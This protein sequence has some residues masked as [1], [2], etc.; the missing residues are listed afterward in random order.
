MRLFL[1]YPSEVRSQVEEVATR[2]RA[3]GHRVFFAPEDLPSGDSFDDRIRRAIRQ[4]DAFLCFLTPEF[5]A[6]GRYT[7]SELEIARRK[8]PSP[9]GHVLPVRVRELPIEAVPSYLRAV[10]ILEPKGNLAA[11]VIAALAGLKTRHTIKRVTAAFTLLAL[12][13]ALFLWYRQPHLGVTKPDVRLEVPG[14]AGNPDQYT[15]TARSAY[16]GTA[17]DL[18]Q[19]RVEFLDAE[20]GQQSE[21]V[22]DSLPLPMTPGS[23]PDLKF[24]VSLPQ[25]PGKRTQLR[26]CALVQAWSCSAWTSVSQS[27]PEGPIPETILHRITAVTKANDTFFVAMTNPTEV[28]QLGPK[29]EVLRSVHQTGMPTAITIADS[30]VYIATAEPDAVSAFDLLTLE[31]R[32][33]LPITFNMKPGTALHEVPSTEVHSIAANTEGVWINTG[34]G[35]NSVLA[36]ADP[37]NRKWIVPKYQDDIAFDLRDVV[38]AAAGDQIWGA[39]T[40]S[41]PANVYLFYAS[42]YVLLDGHTYDEIGC[43]SGTSTS[44]TREFFLI[45]CDGSIV[46]GDI[47]GGAFKVVKRGAVLPNW[48]T[49]NRGTW[50][51]YVAVVGPKIAVAVNVEHPNLPTPEAGWSSQIYAGESTELAP[52]LIATIPGVHVN[53]LAVTSTTVLAAL[54]H[55]DRSR[56]GIAIPVKR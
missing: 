21:W 1:S 6:L 13:L 43:A 54:I 53:S 56:Q 36:H 9:T 23:H 25:R 55:S 32:W 47:R 50:T 38:L 14:Y 3:A 12:L 46:I 29:G 24:A 40:N 44:S 16:R 30:N 41:T 7:L 8:W 5:V 10:T 37:A 22:G 19:T 26:V 31:P 28:A 33:Q 39:E 17:S 4:S 52:K 15:I 45:N 20:E 35:S 49:S 18:R 48:P 27:A 34:N 42:R 11:D 2:L 51:T